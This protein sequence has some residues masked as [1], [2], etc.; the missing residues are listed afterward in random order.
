ML[1]QQWGC[2][3]LDAVADRSPKNSDRLWLA[4]AAR[5]SMTD[6]F[7]PVQLGPITLPNRIVMAPT[8]AQPSWRW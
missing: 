8:D 7:Q 2:N 6:L 1:A 5:C 3:T 4:F